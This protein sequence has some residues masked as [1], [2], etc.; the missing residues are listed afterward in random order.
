M[1]RRLPALLLA[2]P[3][4]R[5]AL[6]MI[7]GVR[8]YCTHAMHELPRTSDPLACFNQAQAQPTCIYWAPISLGIPGGSRAGRCLCDTVANCGTGENGLGVNGFERWEPNSTAPSSSPTGPTSAPEPPQPPSPGPSAAPFG[9][10]SVNPS[11]RPAPAPSARPSPDPTTAPTAPPEPAP[12]A[13][14]ESAPTAPPEPAPTAP[15]ES[16][17]TAPPEPAPTAAPEFSPTA[18][19]KPAPTAAP[20]PAP[21]RP[22]TFPPTVPPSTPPSA[23]P[24]LPTA[25]PSRNP[26]AAPAP[27]P[28]ASP[29]SP[30]TASPVPPPGAPTRAPVLPPTR[31]PSSPPSAGPS[32]PPAAP[33]AAPSKPPA[34]PSAAPLLPSS[35]PSPRSATGAPSPPP[36]SPPDAAPGQPPAPS[37]APRRRAAPSRTPSGTPNHPTATPSTS[38]ESSAAPCAPHSEAP[39]AAFQS[40][41]PASASLWTMAPSTSPPSAAPSL[42]P[43]QSDAVPAVKDA[44]DSMK[45]AAVAGAVAAAVVGGAAG[46]SGLGTSRLVMLLSLLQ[47][48]TE[49]QVI[50]PET[51]PLGLS[52]GKGANAVYVGGILG[53]MLV[54]FVVTGLHALAWGILWKR[55]QIRKQQFDRLF[56]Q[57]PRATRRRPVSAA[58]GGGTGRHGTTFQRAG[59]ELAVAGISSGEPSMVTDAQMAVRFP[60][61]TLLVPLFMFAGNA[62]FA[63]KLI[64]YPDAV[65]QRVFGV[66]TLFF[67][68]GGLLCGAAW[69][70]RNLEAEYAWNEL[71]RSSLARFLLGPGEWTS[72]TQ[73]H[74]LSCWGFLFCQQHDRYPRFMLVEFTQ[75]LVFSVLASIE[76]TRVR[77]CLALTAAI[78]A[79]LGVYGLFCLLRSPWAA[80]VDNLYYVL[81]SWL[82]TVAFSLQAE[83]FRRELQTHPTMTPIVQILLLVVT[84]LT[85]LRAAMDAILICYGN[86][87]PDW[88]PNWARP[89]RRKRSAD[90][91]QKEMRSTRA[92]DDV[93]SSICP[94]DLEGSPTLVLSDGNDSDELEEATLLSVR[95]AGRRR[96]STQRAAGDRRPSQSQSFLSTT[97]RST[98]RQPGGARFRILVPE[99][100]AGA[101]LGG[102]R[103]IVAP[104]RQ[105][106]QTQF[107]PE[108]RGPGRR[109]SLSG[110]D[111]GVLQSG[112]VLWSPLSGPSFTSPGRLERPRTKSALAP[113]RRRTRLSASS[114]DGIRTPVLLLRRDP[115]DL[116]ASATAAVAAASEV[117]SNPGGSDGGD[118]SGSGSGGSA[119]PPTSRQPEGDEGTKLG[120]SVTTLGPAGATARSAASHLS[121]WGKTQPALPRSALKSTAP[122]DLR[123]L[124]SIGARASTALLFDPAGA[125]SGAQSLLS[126]LGAGSVGSGPLLG[127]YWADLPPAD[128]PAL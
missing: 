110:S 112:S 42:A 8:G 66:L 56:A 87:N 82:Q 50:D 55:R 44:Q 106:T 65:W 51:S 76:A 71:R 38:P 26:T 96:S 9:A 27:R 74:L 107:G 24:M 6:Q 111:C 23:A 109:D 123:S 88:L 128:V 85:F 36:S 17:P 40:T 45:H 11:A 122:G 100:S 103:R 54:V 46:A 68:N 104:S 102:S 60:H 59:A 93:G 64:L 73:M 97:P 92:P 115:Q 15:P 1:P 62:A 47:C 94:I 90:D 28:S 83:T 14:P 98:S 105:S 61:A 34:A 86:Y 91:L 120:I 114:S 118:S 30:P 39:T 117:M 78:A 125:D 22:P 35:A 29:S 5:A 49:D 75:L 108:G 124:A 10:P 12:T 37:A 113:P 48:G 84:V 70:L 16:A 33:S 63:I 18:A 41:A 7:R 53:N 13:P 58:G 121:T 81:T 52:V 72:E 19:P 4:A 2:L 31:A 25:P 20:A 89:V 99:G 77:E 69:K 101:S 119:A 3:A 43:T 116:L 126:P 32:L 21:S 67:F 79:E 127:S 57:A 80:P 95:G